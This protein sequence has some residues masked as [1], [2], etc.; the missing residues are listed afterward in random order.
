MSSYLDNGEELEKEIREGNVKKHLFLFFDTYV[1]RGAEI[2]SK[3]LELT[4]GE[5]MDHRLLA[6]LGK[7]YPSCSKD[8]KISSFMK[9]HLKSMELANRIFVNV[10]TQHILS[11][12]VSE[13]VS[14]QQQIP[15]GQE[16]LKVQQ[17]V[18]HCFEKSVLILRRH[19]EI[20][21][22]RVE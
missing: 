10:S 17:S 8:A 6:K 9:E 1:A 20:Q 16:N 22:Q 7:K 19:A 21:I 5:F 3:K 12:N 4:L 11:C 2:L 13:N 18:N 15:Y 14:F